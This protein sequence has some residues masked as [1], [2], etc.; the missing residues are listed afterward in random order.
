MSEEDGIGP[1]A[2]HSRQSK[3]KGPTRQTSV[4][5]TVLIL[6]LIKGEHLLAKSTPDKRNDADETKK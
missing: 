5:D 3:S 2:P 4:W 6:G 1:S